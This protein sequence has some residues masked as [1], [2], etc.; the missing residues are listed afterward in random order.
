MKRTTVWRRPA[1]RRATE[2]GVTALFWMAWV[3]LISPLLS[4]LMWLIGV[5]LFVD[6]MVV[7]QGYQA[8]LQ[9]LHHYGLVVFSMLLAVSLWIEWNQRHYGRH[10]KRRHPPQAVAAAEAAAG[11]GLVPDALRDLR[12]ARKAELDFDDDD[13]LCIRSLS[14]KNS[15]GPAGG[16]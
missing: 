9:E 15:Q 8:L 5:Q 13:R 7:R 14:G 12:A 2:L 16:P 3:Y 1:V 6:E 4:L 10:E 11:A